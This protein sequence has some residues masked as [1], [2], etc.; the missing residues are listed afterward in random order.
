MSI[1][2]YLNDPQTL[3][4]LVGI[5]LLI[6]FT[7]LP[8]HECAHAYAAHKMGDETAYM[9]GRMTLNPIA[10]LDIFGAIFL[11]LFGFGW[12]KPVPVNPRNFRDYK[13]GTAITAAAGPISNL[14]CAA[15]GMFALRIINYIPVCIAL[16]DTAYNVLYYVFLA[17]Y[18]FITVNLS[19]AIFNLIPIPPLDGS[20]VLSVF[21]PYKV[22]AWLSR[23]QRY[24]YIGF[25]LLLFTGI[26][27]TPL[28]WLINLFYRGLYYLFFWVE[29]IM[30]AIF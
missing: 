21:A 7:V 2:S 29:L 3:L 6:I 25:L 19:L 17:V 8:V 20:R 12:A 13:K 28:N 4:I 9:S 30:K 11:V 23:Y 24:I 16:S 26:L 1:L 27:T 5:R 22:N 15:I 18:Y 10:H 14:L